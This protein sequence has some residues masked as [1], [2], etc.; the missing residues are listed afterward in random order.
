MEVRM[1]RYIAVILTL[2]LLLTVSACGN[3]AKGGENDSAVQNLEKLDADNSLETESESEQESA[4]MKETE[5]TLSLEVF[6]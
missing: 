2:L 1:R 4:A 5:V 6:Q 3:D